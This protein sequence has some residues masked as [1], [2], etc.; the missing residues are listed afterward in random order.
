MTLNANTPVKLEDPSD[1][2][3]AISVLDL[4]LVFPKAV[5]NVRSGGQK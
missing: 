1:F 5:E 2:T 3:S 4:K